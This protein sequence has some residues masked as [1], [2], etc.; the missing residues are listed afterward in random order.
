LIVSTVFPP[1]FFFWT[2]VKTF[3]PIFSR[4]SDRACGLV[5]DSWSSENLPGFCRGELLWLSWGRCTGTVNQESIVERAD[6]A[7]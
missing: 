1:T 6:T 2:S 7:Q 3:Q 4:T 5:S